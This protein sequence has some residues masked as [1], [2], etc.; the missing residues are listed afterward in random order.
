M[1]AWKWSCKVE[2]V[3]IFCPTTHIGPHTRGDMSVIELM[4][5]NW[6]QDLSQEQYVRSL[7]EGTKNANQFEFVGQDSGKKLW[8]LPLDVLRKMG[9]SHDR[10]SLRE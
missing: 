7:H 1:F 6:S 8:S 9:S 5:Q 10:T 4:G 2:L 3:L